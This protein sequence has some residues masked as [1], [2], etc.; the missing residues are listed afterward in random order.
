M[1]RD[2]HAPMLLVGSNRLGRIRA[3]KMESDGG[4]GAR[5]PASSCGCV[6]KLGEARVPGGVLKLCGVLKA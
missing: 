4:A 2:G 1:E 3:E 6:R 5:A